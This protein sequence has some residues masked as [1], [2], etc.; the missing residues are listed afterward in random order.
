MI[1]EAQV[2]QFIHAF[3]LPRSEFHSYRGKILHPDGKEGSHWLMNH[4]GWRFDSIRCHCPNRVTGAVSG[5]HAY[6][7]QHAGVWQPTQLG[8]T[9]PN[10]FR[11]LRA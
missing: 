7:S 4:C 10:Q 2:G 3:Q 11:L 9:Q 5:N 1:E 8:F 6:F